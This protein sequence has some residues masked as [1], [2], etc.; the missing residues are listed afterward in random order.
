[1]N[2]MH[3]YGLFVLLLGIYPDN[4]ACT[5]FAL[6]NQD[7]LYVAKNLDWDMGSGY[8]F[9]N[10][11][12]ESRTLL[13]GTDLSWRARYRSLTFNQLGKDFPLGGMNEKGLVVEELNM[14]P[15]TWVPDSAKTP[16]NEFQL[17]QYLLDNCSSVEGVKLAL[18]R[19]QLKPLFQAL[20]YFIADRQGNILVAECNG[21]E[22]IYHD[23]GQSGIPVLSNNL[24]QE[25]LH[26]LKNFQG[27]GG[28][29]GDHYAGGA[30]I[31]GIAGAVGPVADVGKYFH[32][33]A[34]RR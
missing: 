4:Q 12:G 24:Y 17:V 23:P 34:H 33:A 15:T 31:A 30:G 9:I 20:H 1:M 8:F 21:R 16:V 10:E 14:P 6:K 18:D 7:G 3:Y 13:E 5:T 22:F 27:F 32:V 11:R 25:S 19:L 29:L 26:Y 2:K 28:V